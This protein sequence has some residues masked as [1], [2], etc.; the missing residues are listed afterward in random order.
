MSRRKRD[1]SLRALKVLFWLYVAFLLF[2]VVIKFNGSVEDVLQRME[3]NRYIRSV[4]PDYNL[5][6]IPL[7]TIQNQLD[8]IHSGWAVRNLLGNAVVFIPFGFLLPRAHRCMRR[9]YRVL[10]VSLVAICAIEVTQYVTFLGACDVDDLLL[11]LA[12]CLVGWFGYRLSG[13]A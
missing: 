13:D 3:V 5:N 4:E 12:G 9:W 10:A 11:N 2:F 6:L 7:R 8:H 1:S